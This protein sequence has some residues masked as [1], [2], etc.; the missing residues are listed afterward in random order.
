MPSKAVVTPPRHL[1]VI[2]LIR[3]DQQSWKADSTQDDLKAIA[4]TLGTVTERNYAKLVTTKKGPV[5]HM[6]FVVMNATRLTKIN[7]TLRAGNLPNVT[8]DATNTGKIPAGITVIGLGKFD[9]KDTWRL[10]VDSLGALATGV[11]VLK[12]RIICA[13]PPAP[14][15]AVAATPSESK[16][17]SDATAQVA[18]NA[19]AGTGGGIPNQANVRDLP[20]HGQPPAE[21]EKAPEAPDTEEPKAEEGVLAGTGAGSDG[22][23]KTSEK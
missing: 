19:P 3:G 9:S 1:K 23:P 7:P 13:V 18:S 12:Q 8:A 20:G 4:T 15:A 22:L 10:T 16:A 21:G 14:P 5:A 11:S 17:S 2:A 6:L